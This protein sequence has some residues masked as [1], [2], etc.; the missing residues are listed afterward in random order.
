MLAAAVAV[1]LIM[2]WNA[3]S[4]AQQGPSKPAAHPADTKQNPTILPA[5]SDPAPAPPV[6][7]HDA[8]L[9]Q[10]LGVSLRL[11]EKA[12]IETSA[13][14]SARQAV[15]VRDPEQTWRITVEERASR[16]TKLTASAVAADMLKEIREAQTRVERDATGRTS[17]VG[18]KVDLLGEPRE[19]QIGGRPASRFAVQAPTVDRAAIAT[20]YAVALREPGRFVVFTAS[21]LPA[22]LARTTAVF[23]AILDAATFPDAANS[24]ADRSAAIAAGD[25]LVARLTHEQVE[26]AL[27]RAPIWL[28]I[29][30]P[31]PS[32]APADATEVAYQKVEIRTG[33][34]AD[35]DPRRAPTKDADEPGYIVRSVA[36]YVEQSRVVDSESVAFANL[37]GGVGVEKD[38]EAWTIRMGI[39][40]KKDVSMWTETGARQGNRLSVRVVPPAAAP[41][42]KQWLAPDKAYMP[43]VLAHLLPRILARTA[44][45]MTYAFYAYNSGAGDVALRRESLEPGAAGGWILRTRMGEGAAERVT[46]LDDKGDLI[47]TEMGD[48]TVIEPIDVDRL[49]TLWK[50]KGLPTD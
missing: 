36:R 6:L 5:Q 37:L 21:C 17:A 3:A 7:R 20:A 33:T 32:G 8:T 2:A 29:Y 22:E 14:G 42:E 28:R 18:S 46:Y 16:D 39:K 35:L 34:R 47:R 12:L 31:A 48:G 43:Q 10:A 26:A 4:A 9:F 38:A 27:P 45:P 49:Q 30:R 44:T 24:I 25:D 19:A 41:T 40:E 50:S 1:P 13:I 15:L 23:D 11:P